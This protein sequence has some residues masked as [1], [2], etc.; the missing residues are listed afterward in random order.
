MGRRDDRKK[1]RSGRTLSGRGTTKKR[2]GSSTQQQASQKWPSF[3]EWPFFSEQTSTLLKSFLDAEPS[4]SSLRKE[5]IQLLNSKNKVEAEADS[6]S[7][8]KRLIK[9]AKRIIKTK[10]ISKNDAILQV[11]ISN[12]LTDRL[13]VRRQ[14][15]RPFQLKKWSLIIKKLRFMINFSKNCRI[16]F[17]MNW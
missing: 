13:A 10:K 4:I 5:E 8:I 3:S 7:W 9:L 12:C 6:F 11:S 1:T 17:K 16:L 14:I 2:S 15:L